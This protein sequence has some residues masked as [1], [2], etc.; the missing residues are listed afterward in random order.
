MNPLLIPDIFFLIFRPRK[1]S[2]LLKLQLIS[3]S[4]QQIIRNHGWH[5]VIYIKNNIILEYVLNNFKFKKLQLGFKCTPNTYINQLKNCTVLDL[6]WSGVSDT[7]V[8]EL[9]NC[10]ILNLAGTMITDYGLMH[11]IHCQQLDLSYCKYI[12]DFSVSQLITCKK[13]NL[14]GTFISEQCIKKLKLLGCE[15]IKK[16]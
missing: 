10:Q 5:K 4:H 3:K 16:N 13:L 9:Q 11:L 6:S 7:D 14:T 8:I 2:H 1:I 12:S 15:I